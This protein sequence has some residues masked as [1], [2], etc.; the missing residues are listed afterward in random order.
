MG[1]KGKERWVVG[2]GMRGEKTRDMKGT[3]ARRGLRRATT[4]LWNGDERAAAARETKGVGRLLG[5]R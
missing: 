3:K 4:Q 5:L 1:H 2:Q